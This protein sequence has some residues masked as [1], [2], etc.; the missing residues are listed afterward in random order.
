MGAPTSKQEARDWGRRCRQELRGGPK[1]KMD[2]AIARRFFA[3]LPA[4]SPGAALASSLPQ[5]V[6][7][8]RI[9]RR[10]LAESKRVYLPQTGPGGKMRLARFEGMRQMAKGESGILEPTGH[11]ALDKRAG[12]PILVPGLA[13]DRRGYRVGY[14]GGYYDRYLK[15]YPGLK[16][17]L[18]YGAC[19]LDE[20][21]ADP[22]DQP[23][24]ILLTEGG[25]YAALPQSI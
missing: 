11:T 3:L 1:N 23:V 4:D 22:W 2:T 13:F 12:L 14:G 10:L 15:N 17:G 24:D 20:I 8:R 21:E 19:L 16:I 5:E 9:L 6:D 18:C 25:E 7:T